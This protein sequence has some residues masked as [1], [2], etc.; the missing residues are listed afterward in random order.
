MFTVFFSTILT[1]FQ[2][3]QA[4]D[5]PITRT[6]A[7]LSL[8]CT[9]MSLSYGCNYI[10]IFSMMRSM[11]HASQWVEVGYICSTGM[12]NADYIF[13][14]SKGDNLYLVEHLGFTCYACYLDSTVH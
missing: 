4:A 5:D 12:T 8:I 1:M 11:C 13:L 3:P 7:L 6:F 9:L 14:G 2:I 10:V